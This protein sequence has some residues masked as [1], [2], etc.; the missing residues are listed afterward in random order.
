MEIE[1]TERIEIKDGLHKGAIIGIEYRDNP[2][3]NTYIIID[4]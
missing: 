3:S 2:Y 4:V 1:V